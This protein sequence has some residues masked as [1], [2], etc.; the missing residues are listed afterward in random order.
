MYNHI[1]KRSGQKASLIAD[2]VYETIMQVISHNNLFLRPVRVCNI[3]VYCLELP[4][5]VLCLTC[6]SVNVVN[7]FFMPSGAS[8]N[9]SLSCKWE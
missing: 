5:Y 7:M 6:Y 3:Y 1:D 4:D 8:Y 9:Y 2:D